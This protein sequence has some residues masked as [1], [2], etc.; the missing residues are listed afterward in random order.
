MKI[1]LAVLTL[2]VVAITVA[3]PNSAKKE[4]RMS[5]KDAVQ[6]QQTL[7]AYKKALLEF[8]LVKL[9]GLCT[10][11]TREMILS[12]KTADAESKAFL[13]SQFQEMGK[14]MVEAKFDPPSVSGITVT[15]RGKNK[16][17]KIIVDFTKRQ[18]LWLIAGA[19]LDDS[20]ASAEELSK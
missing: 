19:M 14:T 11:E 4:V 5:D 1:R 18:G 10:G 3:K 6:L 7:T 2:I 16:R 15:V 12:A 9:E 17:T 20:E 13:K 8:D